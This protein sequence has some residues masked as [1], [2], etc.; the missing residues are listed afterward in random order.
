MMSKIEEYKLP[1]YYV[2]LI[3]IIPINKFKPEAFIKSL[4]LPNSIYKRGIN[5]NIIPQ[6]RYKKNLNKLPKFRSIFILSIVIMQ[7]INLFNCLY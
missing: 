5:K 6:S 7:L 2:L 3:N 1:K 4:G